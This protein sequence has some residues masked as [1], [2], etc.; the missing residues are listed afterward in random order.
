MLDG[1]V[2][3]VMEDGDGLAVEGRTEVI[4]VG[5]HGAVWRDWDGVER[6]RL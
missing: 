2:L 5:T 3:R 4:A 6:N 1:E